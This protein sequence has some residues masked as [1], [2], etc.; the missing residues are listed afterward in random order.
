MNMLKILLVDDES[1]VLQGLTHILSQYC[2]N[3]DIVGAVQNAADAMRLL[4]VVHVDAVITDVKMPDMDGVELTKQIRAQYPETSVIVHSGYADFEFV[5]QTMKYGACDY[6]LKPCHYQSILKILFNIEESR[7]K[8]GQQFEYRENQELLRA[9]LTGKRILPANWIESQPKLMVTLSV[10]SGAV[11]R[12]SELLKENWKL[13]LML[14]E[15]E[16][17]VRNDLHIVLLFPAPLSEQAFVRKLSDIQ[18]FL[19]MQGFGSYWGISDRF[20]ES[21]RLRHVYMDCLQRMEFAAFNELLTILTAESYRSYMEKQK[22]YTFSDYFSIQEVGK[23]FLK[24]DASKLKQVVEG[25]IEALGRHRLYW[26][27]K[28]LKNEVL[29]EVLHL[30]EY[31]KNHGMQPVHGELIDYVDEV[32]KQATFRDLMLWVKHIIASFYSDTEGEKAV[33]SFIQTAVQLMAQHYMEDI[34][35]KTVSDAVFLNPWYFSTQFKKYMNVSFSEYVNQVRVRMAKQFLKQK[36]LKVYQV[37]EM[38]GFQ[39][40]GYFSTVFKNMEQMSPKDYQKTLS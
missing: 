30:D 31:L 5:R 16:A 1:T 35:L 34:S 29:K 14:Q 17:M 28:R 18:Q 27:P 40:A 32:K 7:A 4:A 15:M 3:Y 19:H 10:H 6:L 23:C 39:D 11:E 36:N 12:V 37:A 38:V 22:A 8:E 9:A 13:G 24:G 25:F 26:D 21:H 20:E 33:P 2:P